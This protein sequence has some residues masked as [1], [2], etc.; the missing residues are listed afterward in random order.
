MRTY[1]EI[2]KIIG[3]KNSFSARF[4]YRGVHEWGNCMRI[5]PCVDVYSFEGGYKIY[6]YN[7]NEYNNVY[8]PHGKYVYVVYKEGIEYYCDYF[9]PDPEP[10]EYKFT[11][12]PTSPWGWKEEEHKYLKDLLKVLQDGLN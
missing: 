3:I 7:V 12:F 4:S 8:S 5:T 11:T 1:K 10:Y 2:T 6:T 9:G